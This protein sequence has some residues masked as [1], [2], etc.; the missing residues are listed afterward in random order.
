M[1]GMKIGKEMTTKSGQ[2]SSSPLTFYMLA[3][4]FPHFSNASLDVP[5]AG[6]FL[7]SAVAKKLLTE[8][9]FPFLDITHPSEEEKTGHDAF[10][11]GVRPEA[12]TGSPTAPC[13]AN[14]SQP[15]AVS[16][17]ACIVHTLCLGASLHID[18]AAFLAWRHPQ[19]LSL[20]SN[21]TWPRALHCLFGRQ[22]DDQPSAASAMPTPAAAADSASVSDGG[23]GV[24]TP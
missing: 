13:E 4:Q 3:F 24:G 2:N 11:D 18:A 8:K 22:G 7:Q 19:H 1:A 21:L 6:H 17:T 9:L 5:I 20:L 16:P 12:A 23:D 14:S 15:D 10:H